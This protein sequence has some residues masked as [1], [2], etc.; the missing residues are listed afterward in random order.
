MSYHYLNEAEIVAIHSKILKK[1]KGL[2]GMRSR[3]LLSSA[4]ESPKMQFGGNELYPDIYS[5]AA[6][7]LFNLVVNHPFLDGNKRTAS[8]VAYLFLKKNGAK[9]PP[10]EP[11]E[12]LIIKVAQGKSSM[13]EVASFFKSFN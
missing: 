1:Y 2:R 5:K 13:E 3:G 7:Y 8:F 12:E 4:V 11:Y 10:L 6:C 9:L